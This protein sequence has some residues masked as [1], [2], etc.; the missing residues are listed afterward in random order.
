M[1]S[2]RRSTSDAVNCRL[3]WRGFSGR[4]SVWMTIIPSA[5]GLRVRVVVSAGRHRLRG[6]VGVG[7]DDDGLVFGVVGDG[8]AGSVG[9]VGLSVDGPG[10]E[11]VVVEDCAD[12]VLGFVDG[13]AVG[14]FEVVEDVCL[15]CCKCGELVG[16]LVGRG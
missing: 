5:A 11:S 6:G 12:D 15:R 7:N 9:V 14:C 1:M 8:G 10:G 16:W 4:A 13:L 3:L 2:R